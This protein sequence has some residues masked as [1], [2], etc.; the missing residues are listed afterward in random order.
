MCLKLG[1]TAKCCANGCERH[2]HY[3]CLE[4]NV[5]IVN[6]SRCRFV[7]KECAGLY[8]R[9]IVEKSENNAKGRSQRKSESEPF[10]VNACSRALKSIVVKVAKKLNDEEKIRK[11]SKACLNSILNRVCSTK[12]R[13]P[14]F[15]KTPVKKRKVGALISTEEMQ[16]RSEDRLERDCSFVLEQIVKKVEKTVKTREQILEDECKDVMNT[17]LRKVVKRLGRRKKIIMN[18][19]KQTISKSIGRSSGGNATSLVEPLIDVEKKPLKNV[20]PL[21]HSAIQSSLTEGQEVASKILNIG[22]DHDLEDEAV[23]YDIYLDVLRRLY[24]KYG[25]SKKSAIQQSA[26]TKNNGPHY[27]TAL[28]ASKEHKAAA[29]NQAALI[30]ECRKCVR[31]LVIKTEATIYA[32]EESVR[33]IMKNREEQFKSI[34]RSSLPCPQYEH[35]YLSA[36]TLQQYLS[37]LRNK[38][39]N[40]D[41]MAPNVS[42]SQ[43]RIKRESALPIPLG[44]SFDPSQRNY[45]SSKS[46]KSSEPMKNLTGCF[47]VSKFSNS[48]GSNIYH[49]NSPQCQHPVQPS[50]PHYVPIIPPGG[51]LSTTNDSFNYC[52]NSGIKPKR[53]TFIFDDLTPWTQ[54]NPPPP[55]NR[56]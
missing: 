47:K 29:E 32:E 14:S 17:I 27:P 28:G 24:K 2:Y 45:Y 36:T 42:Y 21:L 43:L 38:S 55:A 30:S 40:Y 19:E 41:H 56:S 51:R 5:D 54:I 7:C 1:A 6:K 53:F 23:L 52:N 26:A 11:E 33:R 13:K 3:P 9:R 8:D 39:V 15:I 31:H 18:K 46:S 50:C 16:R 34:C 48:I 25:E 10:L 4:G 49:S 37:R 35:S 20:R 12:K 22:V 44:P